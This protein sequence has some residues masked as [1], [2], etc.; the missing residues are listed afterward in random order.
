[1]ID[2]VYFTEIPLFHVLNARIT[3]GN[4]FAMD[5]GVKGVHR[6][7]EEGRIS[8]A[9]DDE[10]FEPPPSYTHMGKA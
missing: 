8:C 5:E 3:F 2:N 6:I 7:E 9:L 4:I 1:M 10:C